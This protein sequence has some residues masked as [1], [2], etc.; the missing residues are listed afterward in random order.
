MCGTKGSSLF[1]LL[2]NQSLGLFVLLNW[3]S[4]PVKQDS[5]S[6]PSHPP[7]APGNHHFTFCFW[8]WLLQNP[9]GSGL[10]QCFVLAYFTE[11]RVPRDV[12]ACARI[13]FFFLSWIIF[14]C[15]YWPPFMYSSSVNEHFGCF[16][17]S[18][19][20]NNTAMNMGVQIS[21]TLFSILSNI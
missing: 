10:I 21:E 8:V 18:V 6:L 2:G 1:I 12:V 4:V 15:I 20:M 7:P 3:N 5:S 11:P 17:L 16:F 13:S 19:I 9:Q 14:H